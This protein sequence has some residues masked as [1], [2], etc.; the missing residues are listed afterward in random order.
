LERARLLPRRA[1]VPV[2]E[3]DTVDVTVWITEGDGTRRMASLAMADPDDDE[4][5]E[6]LMLCIKGA[7]TLRGP[8]LVDAVARWIRIMADD[9]ELDR[10][11]GARGYS[12][13]A[14]II[15]EPFVSDVKAKPGSYLVL[16]LL[17]AWRDEMRANED[18]AGEAAIDSAA[19]VI[20]AAMKRRE[21]I[22]NE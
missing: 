22:N 6:M 17:E 12:A 10:I 3:R 18:L 8:G 7:A 15:D 11:G 13:D 2:E 4:L 20:T 16:Q 19:K 9:A 14:V 5:A 21:R 1:Q